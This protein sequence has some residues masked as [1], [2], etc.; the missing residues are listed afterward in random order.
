M[1]HRSVW[2]F[3][4]NTIA[5]PVIEAGLYVSAFWSEKAK[6]KRRGQQRTL[7]AFSDS[8]GK[9]KAKEP[10][11]WFHAAS[12]GEFLLGATSHRETPQSLPVWKFSGDILLAVG[13]KTDSGM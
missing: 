10:R 9:M 1:N 5:E 11:L 2:P 8:A 13:R 12:A 6:V 4:Y 3:L 7:D